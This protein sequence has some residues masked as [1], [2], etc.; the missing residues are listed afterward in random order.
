MDTPFADR[1]RNPPLPKPFAW[2][3]LVPYS[4]R[5]SQRWVEI[6]RAVQQ[7]LTHLNSASTVA[8]KSRSSLQSIRAL[9]SRLEQRMES[10]A[11]DAGGSPEASYNAGEIRFEASVSAT[12][13]L[14]D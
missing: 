1:P 6:R 4:H 10:M 12:F 11:A 7:E 8:M 3:G 9:V 14:D 13:E 5:S 2:S